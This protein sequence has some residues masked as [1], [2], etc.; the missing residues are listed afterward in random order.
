MRQ[1]SNETEHTQ[2]PTSFTLTSVKKKA[3]T[4]RLWKK[5][6]KFLCYSDD[7]ST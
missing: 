6:I 4:S 2:K 1:G 7:S 3:Q 5:L